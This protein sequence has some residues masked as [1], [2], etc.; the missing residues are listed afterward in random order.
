M[1]SELGLFPGS[2]P[3]ETAEERDALL[4][5]VPELVLASELR[6]VRL[7]A[8]SVLPA[9]ASAHAARIAS[10]ADPAYL[11]RLG[12]ALARVEARAARE[13]DGGLVFLAAS[14][15]YFVKSLA[16]E[17]HPLI[18]ALYFSASFEAPAENLDE[19]ARRMDDYESALP[20]LAGENLR[21]EG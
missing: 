11:E 10:L 15:G 13:H 5:C 1:T 2:R 21:V 3:A 19:I 6:E 20:S 7:P 14:L 17:R 18:V 16:P 8:S 4:R 9:G 12:E